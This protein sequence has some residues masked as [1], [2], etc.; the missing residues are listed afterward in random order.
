MGELTSLYLRKALSELEL[1]LTWRTDPRTER[2]G[3][4]PKKCCCSIPESKTDT[5]ACGEC[6][7]ELQA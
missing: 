1:P 3:G 6:T 4:M 5:I 2:H 7:D